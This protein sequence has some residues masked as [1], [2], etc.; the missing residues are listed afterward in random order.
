MYHATSWAVANMS[1]QSSV[2]LDIIRSDRPRGFH[3]LYCVQAM[4]KWSV[5]ICIS[6][7]ITCA[8][9]SIGSVI[10]FI[11][12][13]TLMCKYSHLNVTLLFMKTIDAGL[14]K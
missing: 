12:C 3:V 7:S 5:Q 4:S 14:L 6:C 10:C 11:T 8:I 1:E 9:C 13:V 2:W